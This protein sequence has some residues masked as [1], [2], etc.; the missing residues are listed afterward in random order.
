MPVELTQT[1]PHTYLLATQFE[2]NSLSPGH[3]AIEV[4]LRD[5]KADKTTDAYT[6]GYLSKAE[7]DVMK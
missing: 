4:Q 7:F 1:G 5:M 6:K 3:Y 2:P